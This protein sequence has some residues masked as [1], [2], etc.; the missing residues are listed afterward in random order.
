LV[1]SGADGDDDL[2]EIDEL[3]SQVPLP[4]DIY[5]GLAQ[6]TSL[7][8]S[9]HEISKELEAQAE[10]Q[11]PSRFGPLVSESDI[12]RWQKASVEATERIVMGVWRECA[13][14][15]KKQYPI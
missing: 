11:R 15:R 6:Y 13:E 2:H 3:F 7:N 12:S 1:Y 5:F 14:Y 8:S 9:V 4:S 10:T